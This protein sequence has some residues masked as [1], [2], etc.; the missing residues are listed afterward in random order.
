MKKSWEI[1]KP[2][3]LS[4][5]SKRILGSWDGA[6]QFLRDM[7]FIRATEK[8]NSDTFYL[9]PGCL[10][11]ILVVPPWKYMIPNIHLSGRGGGGI[12]K[13]CKGRST[14]LNHHEIKNLNWLVWK[15]PTLVFLICSKTMSR[16]VPVKSGQVSEI[17][18]WMY[19]ETSK[20]LV[21]GVYWGYNPVTNH[22]S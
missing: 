5:V 12:W 15:K 10:I 9:N 4:V 2:L 11:A 6:W 19:Q 1:I 17:P 22:W 21:N 14:H 13:S 3:S 16:T 18:T 20:W 7:L 8:K